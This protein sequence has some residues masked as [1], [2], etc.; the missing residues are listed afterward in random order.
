MIINTSQVCRLVLTDKPLDAYADGLVLTIGI[1][2]GFGN[3]IKLLRGVFFVTRRSLPKMLNT[4]FHRVR[5]MKMGGM[6]RQNWLNCFAWLQ[7]A[8][9]NKPYTSIAL[10]E[11]QSPILKNDN[12][13]YL[14]AY[15]FT[16][17]CLAYLTG[18]DTLFE[19]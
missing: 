9:M 10:T 6:V 13:G 3:S 1:F 19:H 8:A 2:L 15:V 4:Y 11:Q 17:S 5:E 16:F 7:T 14:Q 12:S 18:R